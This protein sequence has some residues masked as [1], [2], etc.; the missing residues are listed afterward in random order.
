MDVVGNRTDDELNMVFTVDSEAPVITVT[1]VITEIQ[2]VENTAPVQRVSHPGVMVGTRALLAG[3]AQTVIWATISE[4]GPAVSVSAHVHAPDG[5]TL[6]EQVARSGD[7]YWLDLEPQQEGL[8][9]LW[10]EAKDQAG[11]ASTAGPFDI[12]VL[13]RPERG[14]RSQPVGGY[15]WVPGNILMLRLAA[16]RSML[17]AAMMMAMLLICAGARQNSGR[18]R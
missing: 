10:L 17:L 6:R 12:E 15:S 5:T 8:H 1:R 2:L 16:A 14:D 11:N 4:N 13:G 18:R 9:T 3:G 7:G